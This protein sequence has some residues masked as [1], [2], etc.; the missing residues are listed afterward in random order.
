MFPTLREGD[1]HIMDLVG[2]F[3]HIRST[4]APDVNQC[5]L[6]LGAITLAD[7]VTADG[8]RIDPAAYLC[9]KRT[10]RPSRLHWPRVPQPSAQ[11]KTVWRS[12]LSQVVLMD[13]PR[14][15]IKEKTTCN[16]GR[17]NRSDFQCKVALGRWTESPL[18][19][20][21]WPEIRSGTSS[22]STSE[23]K[24]VDTT[25]GIPHTPRINSITI[26]SMAGIRWTT[27]QHQQAP[28]NQHYTGPICSVCLSTALN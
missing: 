1:V 22:F 25:T 16:P 28:K 24:Y 15:K 13:N 10:F 3:K 11:Q 6:Y 18:S 19:R 9:S 21:W 12:F 4:R 20:Q 23:N 27:L 17:I 26:L 14:R 8:R 2:S 5:R 7:I